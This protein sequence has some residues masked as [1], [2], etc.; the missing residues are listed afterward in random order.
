MFL[1]GMV[2]WTVLPWNRSNIRGP[3][4]NEGAVAEVLTAN[5]P[6]RVYVLPRF[7][8]LFGCG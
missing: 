6:V 3:L 4:R 5:A 1:W 2:S 8:R 7:D